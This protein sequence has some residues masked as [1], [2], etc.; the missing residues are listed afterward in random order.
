MPQY[1]DASPSAPSRPGEV[2]LR[3][4]DLGRTVVLRT[5]RGVFSPER[6]DHGTSVL[7]DFGPPAPATGDLLDLGCGYGPIAVALALRCPAATVW[8]VDVNERAR[9]LC[10][11][12]AVELGLRNLRVAAPDEVPAG[13]R[14]AA[15]RS[16][17]PIRIGQE[18]LHEL[19]TSWLGRLDEGGEAVLVVQKHLGADPLAAWL[20]AQGW[21]VE[22]LRSKQGF[23]LLQV[24]R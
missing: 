15:I 2:E 17:P 5:D 24:R 10:E 8:A 21:A 18:A 11:A 6:V 20:A 12:N 7:L 14:F 3:L 1:F 9:G 16:N 22:R 19:L 23:R 13:V 4:R